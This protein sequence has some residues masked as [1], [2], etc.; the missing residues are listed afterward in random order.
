MQEFIWLFSRVSSVGVGIYTG[1]FNYDEFPHRL[2]TGACVN[3]VLLTHLGTLSK[4]S[5]LH[6]FNFFFVYT[7][8]TYLY[9]I[10]YINGS[11]IIQRIKN[12]NSTSQF[13]FPHNTIY[14]ILFSYFS[15]IIS[16]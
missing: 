11:S 16:N 5:A 3:A 12:E 6:D 4:R 1:L 2:H 14:S 13:T 7:N 10:S 9:A 15:Q 8:Y